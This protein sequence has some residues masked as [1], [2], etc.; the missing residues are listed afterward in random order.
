[1]GSSLETAKRLA[2]LAAKQDG[3]FTASQAVEAGYVDSVHGY[4]LGNGD[5]EKIQRGIYRLKSHPLPVR[6]ELALWWLWSRDKEGRPE[7]VYSH[8]TA[9]EI[10]GFGERIPG[11]LHMTVPRHFRRNTELPPE[12]ELH[13]ADLAPDDIEQ[14][15]GFAV[16][17]L[18]RTVQD[19]ETDPEMVYAL[20][21]VRHDLPRP[22]RWTRT[23]PTAVQTY[24]DVINQGED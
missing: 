3:Y 15:K 24:D 11:P 5:W 14:R 19:L 2:D 21:L 13:K 6:P 12:L 7:G 1:M 23:G 17:T 18:A 4:H 9:L 20:D 16:T 22:L 10:H 8:A